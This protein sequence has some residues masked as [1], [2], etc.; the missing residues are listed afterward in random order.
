MK[1]DPSDE[2]LG[3]FCLV[4]TAEA[5]G[6]LGSLVEVLGLLLRG[7]LGLLPVDEAFGLFLNNTPGALP[8]DEVSRF[9]FPSLLGGLPLL[10]N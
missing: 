7:S 4:P 2:A 10:F 9:F 1:L 5:L 8:S 6:C 3:P